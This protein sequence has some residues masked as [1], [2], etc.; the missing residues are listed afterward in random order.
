MR[1]DDDDGPD[2]K[3][4][5][6]MI[7]YMWRNSHMCRVYACG[8]LMVVAGLMWL[9]LETLQDKF[10]ALGAYIAVTFFALSGMGRGM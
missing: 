6:L 10:I 2:S 1:P 4:L 7:L 9:P 5:L 8:L 3:D